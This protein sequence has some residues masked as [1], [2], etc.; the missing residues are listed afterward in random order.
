MSL[1]DKIVVPRLR[2]YWMRRTLR[3]VHYADRPDRLDL[4]YRVEDP[5]HMSSAKEQARF[6]WINQ[7]IERELGPLDSI[8]EIG[9]GEG[10]QSQYLSRLC[11]RLYGIDVSARAVSR[12]QRRCPEAKFVSGDPFTFSLDDMTM[13]V[14]LVVACEMIYYVKDVP[15]L[16][17]RLSELGQACLVTYY[18]G[19]APALGSYFAELADCRREYFRFGD[20][21]WNAIWWRNSSR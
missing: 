4:I 8:L 18:Q 15:S 21:E 1:I 13:P 3:R 16:I 11:S 17:A 5:W 9:C 7:L 19:Q 20:V 10:H 2:R 12:A 6:D 14:D